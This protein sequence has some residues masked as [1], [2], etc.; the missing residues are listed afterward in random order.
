MDR[1]IQVYCHMSVHPLK[2]YMDI[3]AY[4][5][6]VGTKYFP[7]PNRVIVRKFQ[8]VELI[9]DDCMIL[10]NGHN[11]EFSI[12]GESGVDNLSECFR[13]KNQLKPKHAQGYF[14][15]SVSA[16]SIL[17]LIQNLTISYTKRRKLKNS[18]KF[19]KT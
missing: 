19:E 2:T 15:S 16:Q 5:K 13:I 7:G 4:S 18:V 3:D 11:F 12:G 1:Q 8:K 9:Y 14:H 17:K 10:M 6:F